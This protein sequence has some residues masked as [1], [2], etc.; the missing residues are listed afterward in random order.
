LNSA[1]VAAGTSPKALWYLARGTGL[2]SLVLLTGSLLLGILQVSRWSS[3]TWP[4]F[5]TQGLHRNLSLLVVV[6]LAVHIVTAELDVFAPVGWLAVAVPF[7]SAYRPVWLGLGTLAFD[8]LIALVATSLVRGRVGYR[9]WRV[10]HWCAYAS[11]PVAFVHGLGTGTD[12]RLGWVMWM[13]WG[14]AAA[15]LAAGSWRLARGWPD[16]RARRLALA[17][18]V[19]VVAAGVVTWS[20]DGP[21]RPGWARRAGTPARLLAQHHGVTGASAAAADEGAR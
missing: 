13:S 14:C 21:L 8:L 16:H 15:V 11:W 17:G 6:V 5:V 19:A 2:V 1:L 12:S 18:V 7:L 4:R 3:P 20:V 10:V 9:A